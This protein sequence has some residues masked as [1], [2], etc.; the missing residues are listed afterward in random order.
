MGIDGLPGLPWGHSAKMSVYSGIL[1]P[2]FFDCGVSPA[3]GSEFGVRM[4]VSETFSAFSRENKIDN[5]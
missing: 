1:Y 2:K 4:T 5:H 3:L